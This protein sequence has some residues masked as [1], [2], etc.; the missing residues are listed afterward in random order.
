M[1]FIQRNG[2]CVDVLNHAWWFADDEHQRFQFLPSTSLE[3]QTPASNKIACC[4]VKELT[5]PEKNVIDVIV[6]DGLKLLENSPGLTTK[7]VHKIE[8][9]GTQPIKQ[10]AYNYSAKVSEAMHLELDKMLHSGVVEPSHSSW[11]SPVVMVRKGDSYRFCIDF[12]KLNQFTKKDSYPMPNIN[13]LLDSLRRAVYLSKLDLKQAFLQV[14]LADEDTK[15]LTSF[16]VPGRGLFRFRTMPFGLTNSPATFQRLVDSVF[17]DLYP[18][19]IAFLDDILICTSDFETHCTLLKE[20]FRRLYESG[21]K[22]NE[23]KC[24]FGCR[25]VRYLGYRVNVDGI[26][27]DPEKSEAVTNY[28]PPRNITEL[29]RFLGM[30]GWYRRFIPDFSSIS[31]PLTSLLG[32]KRDWKWSKE[33]DRAFNRLKSALTSAP[34]L[35]RP[36]FELPFTLQTDASQNGIG[37]ALTQV[38]DGEERV[39]TYCSRSLSSAERNYSVTEKECLAIIFGI[40]KN[41]QYLEGAEFK[42]ITDHSCLKWL[43]N[44]KSPTGRLARWILRLQPYNYSV[45]YR[46]GKFNCVADALSRIP[47]SQEE[48]LTA[49]TR[50]AAAA[51]A[52]SPSS[53]DEIPTDDPVPTL[54]QP[55]TQ[56][57]EW[58]ERKLYRVQNQPDDHPDW[59]IEDGQLY[60]CRK[61][62]AKGELQDPSDNWKLVVPWNLRARILRECHDDLQSGH[63]GV[64]KTHWRIGRLY[65]WPGMYQD[66]IRHIRRCDVCQRVKPQNET[67]RGLMYPRYLSKPWDIVSADLMGPFPCSSLGNRYLLVL[68]DLFTKWVELVPIRVATSAVISNRFRS[69]IL[70]RYGTPSVLITDNASNFI[71]STIQELA[72]AHGIKHTTTPLYHCQANPTERANRNVRQLIISYLDQ[73][74]HS[75]WDAYLG[76]L[77]FALN[78][79]VHSST[80][81][82]PAFLNYGRELQASR[83]YRAANSPARSQPP[84]SD[85]SAHNEW[86]SRMRKLDELLHL[87]EKNL[88][89]A[90][91][92]QSQRYNLRRS[93]ERFKVGDQVLHRSYLLSSSVDKTAAKLGHKY[94]GPFKVISVSPAGSCRLADDQGRDAG[95]WHP[96]KLKRYHT[97]IAEGGCVP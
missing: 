70:N 55:P 37:A 18:H 87:A 19:V 97:S 25:E 71:S 76:E 77:Q 65:Y 58:Y 82:S 91:T 26:S 22:I 64:A 66:V 40:E 94:V 27:V 54:P 72:A 83:C 7:I 63:L 24:E 75:K 81:F 17:L 51:A 23:D 84:P 30:A 50:S 93:S 39:I 79:V 41:R 3:N 2:L 56:K 32:K 92:Q 96:S 21:L 53:A 45:E 74:H 69:V 20:V 85:L 1:D 16:I 9:E 38:H 35:A 15:D 57:D 68:E 90:G 95:I 12:R 78:S 49:I 47:S 5:L 44:L 62:F 46:K 48:C 43:L 80:G 34:V 13:T 14:P 33:Q 36:N 6:S 31:V 60:Y 10:R 29:R 11:A 42:V 86:A 59:K 4:G 28:P 61:S 89:K 52:K 73:E 88:L 67:P 8:I